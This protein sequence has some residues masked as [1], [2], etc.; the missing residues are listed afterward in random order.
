MGGEL[1]EDRLVGLGELPQRIAQEVERADDPSLAAER[2]DEL[3]VRARH[4]F[5]VSW[6]GA[7][8]VD[9][10]RLSFGD[11]GAHQA[12]SH[13]HAERARDVRGVS[14]RVGDGELAAVRIEQI[15][16]EGLKLGEPGDELWNLV[17]QLV[18]VQHRRDLAPEREQGGQRL[19]EARRRPGDGGR[20]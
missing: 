4:G 6:I 5:D 20:G 14:Y 3:R 11:R 7:D 15:D 13:L 16:G 19:A 17:Q 18:E 2:H 10:K 12:V 1:P 8:V 9:E